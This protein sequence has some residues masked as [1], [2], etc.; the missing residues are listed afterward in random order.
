MNRALPSWNTYTIRMRRCLT[1]CALALTVAVTGLTLTPATSQAKDET[2][3]GCSPV[4]IMAFRG[5]GETSVGAQDYRGQ[6]SNGFEG[7]TLQRLLREYAYSD[8]WTSGGLATVPVVSISETDGYDAPGVDKWFEADPNHAFPAESRIWQGANNGVIAGI[9]KMGDFQRAQPAYCPT[10]QWVLVGYSQGAMAAR[11]TFDVMAPRVASLYLVG[12]PFQKPNGAGTLGAGANGT[13]IFRFKWL[14][15]RPSLDAYYAKKPATAVSFCHNNDIICDTGAYPHL[16]AEHT[17]YYK[18]PG[19]KKAH[20]NI[21]AGI[22]K[23]A[24][25][26]SV[27]P[28]RTRDVEIMISVD[29]TGS[30][31]DYIDDAVASARALGDRVLTISPGSRVGLV[32]YRDHGDSFVARTV[33]PLT[34]DV[35]ALAGG[36]GGL[37]ADEGG[38]LPEAVFSGIVEAGRAGWAPGS[39][40]AIAVLGDAPAH[41]PEPVT[42]YTTDSVKAYLKSLGSR[43]VAARSP[44]GRATSAVGTGEES[45]LLFGLSADSELTAQVG[46][47]ANEVG[48]GAFEIGGDGTVAQLLQDVVD[49]TASAPQAAL[50]VGPSLT[51]HATVLNAGGTIVTDGPATYDFDLDGDGVFEQTNADPVQ[52][53]QLTA[54]AHRFEVRVTDA[55]GRV[56][57]AAAETVTLDAQS[58]L[59]DAGR[60]DGVRVPARG[61]IAGKKLVV[62]V[63]GSSE[64][65]VAA[66]V[67]KSGD[68]VVAGSEASAAGAPAVVPVPRRLRPGNYRLVVVSADGRAFSQ[69]V[70]VR[71]QPVLRVKAT[72]DGGSHLLLRVR[73]QSGHG[74]PSGKVRVRVAGAKPTTGKMRSGVATL[75]VSRPASA[76]SRKVTVRL[77]FVKNRKFAQAKR[78]VVWRS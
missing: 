26:A 17:N 16:E 1:S 28:K 34:R 14:S 54:G 13:G 69:P 75:R 68:R 55:K 64:S 48:G 7:P 31:Q 22:V 15:L 21:L 12:D 72:R 33:V 57:R 9:R 35:T 63:K 58:V 37:Y 50:A 42:G 30:M 45:A 65:L 24:V 36:L 18:T 43:V 40:R 3:A 2:R 47:I 27:N 23:A 38:D 66:L 73:A 11:W 39:T 56:A 4:A 6:P 49:E 29:T 44:E 10:T 32:E 59:G 52:T 76:G 71:Q 78:S 25:D 8:V 70:R 77:T 67:K 20:G 51:G 62:S 5:S 46:D 61:A 60:L 53:L 41:D 19:E 74:K